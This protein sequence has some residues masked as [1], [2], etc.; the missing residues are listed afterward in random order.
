MKTTSVTNSGKE[1]KKRSKIDLL[2]ELNY[3]VSL[4]MNKFWVQ[5]NYQ[6]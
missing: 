2:T 1:K 3:K 6:L 4:K 5:E